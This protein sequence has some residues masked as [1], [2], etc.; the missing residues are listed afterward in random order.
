MSS[1]PFSRQIT[2]LQAGPVPEAR[3]EVKSRLHELTRSLAFR[4][5]ADREPGSH[6][7]STPMGQEWIW[8]HVFRFLHWRGCFC[9][10]SMMYT[11]HCLRTK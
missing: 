2:V 6:D 8:E 10:R 5:S 11:K 1:P 7:F 9:Q 4:D 3:A